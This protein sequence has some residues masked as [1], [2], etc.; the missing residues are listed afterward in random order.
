MGARVSE[1][2]DD[3][4]PG[5]TTCI[6]MSNNAYIVDGVRTPGGRRGGRLSG[7]HPADIGG[8]IIDALLER[9]RLNGLVFNRYQYTTFSR[10]FTAHHVLERIAERVQPF[11][12]PTDPFIDFCCGMNT[13]AP[14]MR[15]SGAAQPLPPCNHL[16]QRAVAI[17]AAGGRHL[18]GR[19]PQY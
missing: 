14:L 17:A 2:P 5:R 19:Q 3:V 9:T 16:R 1:R 6:L 8:Y 4:H 15:P 13:F 12:R 18:A 7:W 11:L 10:H